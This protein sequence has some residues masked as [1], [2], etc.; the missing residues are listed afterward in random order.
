MTVGNSIKIFVSHNQIIVSTAQEYC[1]CSASTAVHNRPQS[2]WT[3]SLGALGTFHLC[4]VACWHVVCKLHAVCPEPR[5]QEIRMVQ[6]RRRLPETLC[7]HYRFEFELI[8]G[9]CA[10]GDLSLLAQFP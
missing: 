6:H 1:V 5:L 9:H 8:F 3:L 7:V 4:D 10:F 2:L